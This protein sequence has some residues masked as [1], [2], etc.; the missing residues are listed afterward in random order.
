M[1]KKWLDSKFIFPLIICNLLLL[2]FFFFVELCPFFK[3]FFSFI[4]RVLFPFIVALIISYLLHP[5][6]NLLY[7]QGIP[8]FY[9]VI[10]IY[11]VFL[12][13]LVFVSLNILPVL[14]NELDDF[15]ANFIK[16]DRIFGNFISKYTNTEKL[17]FSLNFSKILKHFLITLEYRVIKFINVAFT[18]IDDFINILF[19]VLIIP[20]LTFY[21]LKDSKALKKSF[22]AFFPSNKR[23]KTL[24][25]LKNISDSLGNYIRG[26]LLV[27]LVVGIL[28]YI[29]YI[30]IGLPYALLF[31]IIASI[32]NI[33]P[34]FGPILGMLG[35]LLIAFT[36]SFKL[37]F[38]VFVVNIIVQT[39]EGNILSP[40]M[41]S[42]SL[43]VHPLLV[44]LIILIGGEL[45]GI[46]G[47]I[48]AIP[49]FI[50]LKVIL[51]NYFLEEE[52]VL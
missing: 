48:F 4:G 44:F 12:C 8:R 16:F 9:A 17:L 41:I 47:L 6:V 49:F 1:L 38:L 21:M 22:V 45:L 2:A 46:F 29:G 30:I 10:F 27:C 13:L 7:R 37:V 50:I 31:S 51:T 19:L 33:I 26:Q 5:F 18:K 14:Q 24:K 32:F 28:N 36:K 15:F 34:Y 25:V 40:Q 39:I 52:K 20:F 43:K 35:A 11:A 42:K 23:K 3:Y